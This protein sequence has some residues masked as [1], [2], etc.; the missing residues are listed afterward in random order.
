MTTNRLP[1]AVIGAGPVGLAAAAHLLSRGETPLVLEAGETAGDGIRAWGHVRLFSPWRYV[2]DPVSVSMLEAAGWTA[3]S[4]DELPTGDDLVDRYLLPLARLPQ[5]APQ[6]RFSTRVVAVA[7]QGFDKL[8]TQGREE[9]PFLLRVQG[10]DGGTEHLLARAV[11]DASGT[12]TSPNPL[13]A[14][15]LP[16]EGETR[17]ADRIAYGIP[18]VLGAE[19]ERYAGRRVLVAGSGHSAFNALLDLAALAEQAPGTQITWAIRGAVARHLYG[20]GEADALPARGQLGQ[21]LRRLVDADAIRLVSGFRTAALRRT[22]GGIEVIGETGSIGPVDEIIAATGFRP[23]LS[24]TSELRR[25][26]DPV[27]ESPAAL[28]PLIDPNVHFCGSVPPH[29]FQ[30]LS[31][32]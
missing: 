30:E 16:A 9:A 5:L 10:A 20:G 12:W 1:V 24:L 4:P 7:R 26:L 21:R 19:R 27:V 29:G 32:P 31:H 15:G 28:A 6:I 18:D 3:P 22:E 11:I 14:G 2:V 13:G 8:K 23:D 25:A 17:L